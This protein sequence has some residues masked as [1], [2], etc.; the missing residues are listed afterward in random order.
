MIEDHPEIKFNKISNEEYQNVI[1]SNSE[2]KF[3]EISAQDETNYNQPFDDLLL[4]QEQ[5]KTKITD[6]LEYQTNLQMVLQDVKG[7]Q[8]L[9]FIN[10]F[11]YTREICVEGIL[12][13]GTC[14][15]T[16]LSCVPLH[17]REKVYTDVVK[18]RPSFK[19]QIESYL[20]NKE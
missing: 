14:C 20:N 10:P 7:G 6:T 12:G 16:C 1:N 19:Y 4:Q 2:F 13:R 9:R 8:H 11:Y 3:S 17:L 5:N 15:Q 18:R